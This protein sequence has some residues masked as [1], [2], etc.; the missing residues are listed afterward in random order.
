MILIQA[1]ARA[2]AYFGVILLGLV[3]V[4][5]GLVSMQSPFYDIA[6]VHAGDAILKVA[7]LLGLGP[8]GAILLAKALTA[9]KLAIGTVLLS[10][11]VFAVYE[12]LR[13]GRDDEMMNIGLMLSAVGTVVAGVPVLLYGGGIALQAVIGELLICVIVGE[14]AAYS[15]RVAVAADAA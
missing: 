7:G 12:S 4:T 11:P 1:S 9:L 13:R 14:L 8:A 5:S 15:R 10:V 2:L 3:W 6:S